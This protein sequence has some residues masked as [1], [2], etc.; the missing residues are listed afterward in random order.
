MPVPDSGKYIKK[1][2]GV[3]KSS[4]AAAIGIVDQ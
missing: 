1:N 3:I 2:S 4:L